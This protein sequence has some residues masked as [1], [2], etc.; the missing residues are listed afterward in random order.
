[1]KI[2]MTIVWILSSVGLMAQTV[3]T[4]QGT[5]RDQQGNP[6]PKV[7]LTFT[8]NDPVATPMKART[9]VSKESGVYTMT[10]LPPVE[11]TIEATKEGYRPELYSYKQGLGKQ[12]VEFY[13]L[14]VEEAMALLE[15]QEPED[16]KEIAKD[17][18]N[19]AVP[20]YKSGKYD[21]AEDLLVKALEQDPELDHAMKLAAYCNHSTKDW[22]QALGFV[23]Q[24]LAMHSD[25]LN[26][27]RLAYQ[28]ATNASISDKA[29]LYREKVKKLE[30]VT[31]ESLYKEAAQAL[32]ANDDE[33]AKP[34]L[35]EILTMDPNYGDAHYQLGL[36][37]LREGDFDQAVKKLKEFI[38]VDPD[39]P[40]VEEAKDL[41]VTLLE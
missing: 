37:Y 25:D 33:K 6:I 2:T 7:T 29:D 30:G 13:M 18:Y 38:K 36:V 20:L 11:L 17:F 24:Y 22:K 3:G 40:K 14:T 39:H 19:Q 9:V 8:P 1:M 27:T 35:E 31:P 28:A 21:E 34:I 10:G 12:T 26:M 32:N 15:E 41:I 5:I 4:A 23:E 16:P